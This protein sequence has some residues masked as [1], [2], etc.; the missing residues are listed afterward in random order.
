MP[1]Y[2]MDVNFY[3]F[4]PI[5]NGFDYSLI[6]YRNI[7]EKPTTDYFPEFIIISCLNSDY[8]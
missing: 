1:G 3:L 5:K 6:N 2:I 7:K 4:L 8:L